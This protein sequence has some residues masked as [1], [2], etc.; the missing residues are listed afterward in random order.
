MEGGGGGTDKLVESGQAVPE[1]PGAR[2]S[3]K[4]YHYRAPKSYLYNENRLF[5]LRKNNLFLKKP[6]VT[7]NIERE[8]HQL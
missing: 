3:V 5:Q 7:L 1:D 2:E 8:S 6:L 4:A